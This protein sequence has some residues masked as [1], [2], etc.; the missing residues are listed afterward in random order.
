M[1]NW[2]TRNYTI[3]WINK[4]KVLMWETFILL[5]HKIL[6]KCEEV[7][8]FLYH[9]VAVLILLSLRIELDKTSSSIKSNNILSKWTYNKSC[10]YSWSELRTNRTNYNKAKLNTH[11]KFEYWISM[12]TFV[13]WKSNFKTSNSNNKIEFPI[14]QSVH[15]VLNLFTGYFP[16]RQ[17]VH[18]FFQFL[19]TNQ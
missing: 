12:K 19:Y 10:L 17:P 3:S 7:S 2:D 16:I 11:A 4:M 8:N 13:K 9:F 15:T 14:K 5:I 1:P 18:T 6:K